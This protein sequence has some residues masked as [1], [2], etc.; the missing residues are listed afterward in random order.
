MIAISLKNWRYPVEKSV[1]PND[2]CVR[3]SSRALFAPKNDNKSTCN[4]PQ[5]IYPVTF[6][7][8]GKIDSKIMISGLN[9]A[10]KCSLKGVMGISRSG[11]RLMRGLSVCAI[12]KLSSPQGIMDRHRKCYIRRS[13]RKQKTRNQK[14]RCFNFYGVLL[15]A[16]EI[17]DAISQ[18]RNQV[19]TSS[20]R[21]GKYK[22]NVFSLF[23]S[24]IHQPPKHLFIF[25]LITARMCAYRPISWGFYFH[26]RD[27]HLDEG[28]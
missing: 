12:I 8:E 10:P 23:L 1:F 25:T 27:N 5:N 11:R 6:I 26:A 4:L 18:F 2:N 28:C 17:G 19:F 24:H 21:T 20:R 3:I 16:P 22:Y 7:T 9:H 14:L 13:S 15:C